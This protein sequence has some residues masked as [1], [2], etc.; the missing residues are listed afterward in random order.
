MRFKRTSFQRRCNICRRSKSEA[1]AEQLSRKK[2]CDPEACPFYSAIRDAIY[3]AERPRLLRFDISHEEILEGETIHLNWETVNCKSVRISNVGQVE[4]SGMISFPAV[5]G[6]R[7]IE[8][9]LVDFFDKVYEASKEIIVREKPALRIIDCKDKILM[10][11][12]FFLRYETTNADFVFLKNENGDIIENLSD[13]SF[14]QS[15]PLSKNAKFIINVIGKYGGEINEEIN[16]KVFEAPYIKYFRCNTVESVDTLPLHFEFDYKNESK[17]EIFCD[18]VRIA[19]VTRGKTFT[20]IAENKMRRIAAPKFELIVTGQTGAKAKAEIDGEIFIYPQ[21]S[22]EGLEISPDNVILFP[23]HVT[24]TNRAAFCEKI[25]LSDGKNEYKIRPNSS[26]NLKSSVTKEY[27]LTPVG[28]QNFHG[29][30]ERIFIE[31]VHPVDIEASVSNT[32]TLPNKPVTIS[33]KSKNHSQIIIEPGKIDA[34]NLNSYDLRLEKKTV[35]KVWGI[36]KRDRKS[37]E[38][39]VDVLPYPKF[40][41]RIFGGLPEL[42]LQIPEIEKIKPLSANRAEMFKSLSIREVLPLRLGIRKMLPANLPAARALP[43]KFSAE[44][45]RIFKSILLK[46]DFNFYRTLRGKMFGELKSIKRGQK[47]L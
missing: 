10:N 47:S 6:T 38:I 12:P 40:D 28:R 29:K 26:V 22:I 36:N 43:L 39:F 37:V 19:D 33:W 16:I 15:Y 13:A 1:I 32:I 2:V 24:L 20:Y 30:R 8:I 44:I 4:A 42:S 21:P 34:T 18:G 11:E 23:K 14:F 17:A 5:S 9:N 25:I 31:V 27:F 35:V 45:L 7:E 46:T 3:E 41:Q